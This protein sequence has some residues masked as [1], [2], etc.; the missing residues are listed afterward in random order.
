MVKKRVFYLGHRSP[1]SAISAWVAA[2]GLP[3]QKEELGLPI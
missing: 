3:I 1:L 2:L